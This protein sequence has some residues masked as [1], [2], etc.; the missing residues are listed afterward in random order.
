[1]HQHKSFCHVDLA[2]INSPAA[3][4]SSV[5][6]VAVA[7]AAA[8][9][10]G[11]ACGASSAAHMLQLQVLIFAQHLKKNKENKQRSRHL[12]SPVGGPSGVGGPSNIGG[13]PRAVSV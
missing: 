5:A 6:A 3:C 7:V 12:F 13:P 8:S 9:A 10:A 11:D 2:C 4:A 1:M